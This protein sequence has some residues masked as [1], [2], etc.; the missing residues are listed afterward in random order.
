TVP[1]TA[2]RPALSTSRRTASTIAQKLPVMRD[3]ILPTLR[4]QINS[5]LIKLI[6]LQCIRTSQISTQMI[7]VS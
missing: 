4:Q 1:G 6:I 7:I 2:Q 3:V 5:E